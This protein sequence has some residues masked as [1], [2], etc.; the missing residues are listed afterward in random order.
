MSSILTGPVGKAEKIPLETLDLKADQT[1]TLESWL[2]NLPDQAIWSHYH[3]SVVHLRDIDGVEPAQKSYPEAEHEFMMVALNPD[4]NPKVDDM[5]SLHPLIPL[6]WVHQWHGLNDE[7]AKEIC[8][9]MVKYLVEGRLPAELQGILG[10][11]ELWDTH[12]IH[13]AMEQPQ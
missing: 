11:R 4:Y 1:A 9:G 12:F 13:L 6:N 2:L 3:L 8:R 10:A 5:D 7:K